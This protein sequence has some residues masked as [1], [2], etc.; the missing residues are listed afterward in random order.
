MKDMKEK[1]YALARH[2][3]VCDT[4]CALPKNRRATRLR[5]ALFVITIKHSFENSDILFAI[6][7][8]NFV[9]IPLR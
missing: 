3:Y 9:I 5:H 1:D 4:T 2:E 7:S 8:Y 6:N